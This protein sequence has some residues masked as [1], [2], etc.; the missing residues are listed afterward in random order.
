MEF[1]SN[2]YMY[3][4]GQSPIDK[5]RVL[6]KMA[7]WIDPSYYSGNFSLQSQQQ[8]QQQRTIEGIILLLF[9]FIRYL[10]FYK[11]LNINFP[12]I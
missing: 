1:R 2:Q 11:I 9:V 8:V 3:K 6:Y 12:R 4:K 5:L 10:Y 7:G